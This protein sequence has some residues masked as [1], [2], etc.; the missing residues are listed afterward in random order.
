MST[1]EERL[2]HRLFEKPLAERIAELCIAETE[3]GDVLS[4]P[5][6]LRTVGAQHVQRILTEVTALYAEALKDTL[7][8]IRE[9]RQDVNLTPI[10]EQL[11]GVQVTLQDVWQ[12]MQDTLTAIHRNADLEYTVLMKL[13]ARLG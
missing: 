5:I 9:S 8:E 1:V 7:D 12:L 13:N 3:E 2:K 10:I 4:I 11:D 6:N